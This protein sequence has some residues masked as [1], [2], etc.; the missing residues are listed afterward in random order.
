[1]DK[2]SAFWPKNIKI[3]Y[4]SS[5]SWS[6]SDEVSTFMISFDGKLKNAQR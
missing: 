4:V 6:P 1:M 2:D 3:R 5:N